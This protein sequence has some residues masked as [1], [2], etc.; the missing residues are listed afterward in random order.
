MNSELVVA[1]SPCPND[2]FI[3]GAWA[4]GLL[5]Q[6]FDLRSSFVWADV[7]E[8]N[9]AATGKK[10]PVIKMSAAQAIILKNDYLILPCG[11]AFGMDAGPKLVV[12]QGDHGKPK[13]VAVPGLKTT[14]VALLQAAVDWPVT[15]HP[16][17]YDRVVDAV[18]SKQCAGGLLIHETSLVPERYG[19]EVALDLGKWWREQES[20]LP[21]PLG[22]IGLRRDMA[23]LEEA[24]IQ[25]IRQSIRIARD[26]RGRIE[27]LIA[28][29]AQELDKETLAAHIQAFVN[30]LSMDMGD[31]GRKALDALDRL[32][33][34]R[35]CGLKPR[36]VGE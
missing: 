32:E 20:G 15:F 33:S 29:F 2:M 24:V 22:C 5:G 13:T 21:L 11:G 3:F 6:E 10:Y 34:A 36:L 30:E 8:L 25:H 14:A 31:L 35:A 18:R 7:E 26:S 17:A 12:R 27:P 4:L 9:A 28:A 19:L 1:I 23:S 16:M